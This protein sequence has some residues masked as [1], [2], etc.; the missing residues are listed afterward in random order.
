MRIRL[1]S[2]LPPALLL[3]ERLLASVR[4]LIPDAEREG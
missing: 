1:I 2:H 4:V 3:G